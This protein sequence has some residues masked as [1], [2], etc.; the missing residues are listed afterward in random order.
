M[1]NLAPFRSNQQPG[2]PT[3]PRGDTIA[4]FATYLEAQKAV[5][6]LSDNHFPVQAVTIV[7]VDLKMVERVTGRLTYARVALA[8]LLSGAW[9]G[10][11]VGLLISL[12]GSAEGFSV[13]AAVFIGAAF[14]LMFGIISYAFTGGRRDF[15]S[16]S[17]IVAGEYRVLCLTEQAG[18]AMQLLDQL[19]RD[20]GPASSDGPRP[21]GPSAP[22]T[23]PVT[24]AYGES[25]EPF[26]HA[27]PAGPEGAAPPAEPVTGPTYSE[28]IDRKKAEERE[29][30]DLERAAQAER[31][32]AEQ[33]LAERER[34]ERERIEKEQAE[35]TTVIHHDP[36]IQRDPSQ[37]PT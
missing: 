32:Q 31:E 35:R 30:A 6:Y 10:L 17:Q 12:F 24:P 11:F 29:Q 13:F 1:S 9:F 14:G 20:G 37:D 22:A 26:P 4:Q 33:K 28:M 3:P 21:G 23:A 18:K 7:G 15:T 16:T 2:L 34:I 8:G 19:A 5:D 27:T 36:T 25:T